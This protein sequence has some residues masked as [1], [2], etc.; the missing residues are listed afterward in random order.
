VAGAHS[1][2]RPAK[3]RKRYG[4][5]LDP[6]SRSFALHLGPLYLATTPHTDKS[7]QDHPFAG[8]QRSFCLSTLAQWVAPMDTKL[9]YLKL[10]P[11]ALLSLT[12][13]GYLTV[14]DLAGLSTV[15][16]LRIPDVNGQDWLKLA[17]ALGREPYSKE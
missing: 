3:L 4:Y 8:I 17:R 12:Q 9:A 15:E 16:I 7:I 5:D 6:P 1:A 13:R 2:S 14:V 10:S 11:D